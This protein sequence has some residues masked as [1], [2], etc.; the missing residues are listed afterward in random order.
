MLERIR[1]SVI[2]RDEVLDGPYGRRRTTYADYTASGRGLTF[3]EDFIGEEVLRR[4]AKHPHRELR[5]R[6]AD[7]P[8]A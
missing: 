2:G 6:P 5:H 8:T 3:I 4:Y 7:Q 1:S